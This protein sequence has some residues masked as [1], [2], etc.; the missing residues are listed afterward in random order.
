MARGLA[1]FRSP[2]IL[3]CTQHPIFSPL[4]FGLGPTTSLALF[5]G[6]QPAPLPFHFISFHFISVRPYLCSAARSPQQPAMRRGR[7][8]DTPAALASFLSYAA[9][10]VR[11]C[12][13]T[14]SCSNI[15]VAHT[16]THIPKE[17]EASN[18]VMASAC[19]HTRPWLGLG[20]PRLH[21]TPLHSTPLRSVP[22]RA[23]AA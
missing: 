10:P 12:M 6:E 15:A 18:R 11:A 17:R 13:G 3:P 1:R 23:Q 14:G 19:T 8:R 9:H 16:H 7:S 21:S 5:H 20:S 4:D 2:I 22:G